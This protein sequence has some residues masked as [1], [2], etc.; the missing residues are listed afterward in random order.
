MDVEMEDA[1]PSRD[2]HL[3][4]ARAGGAIGASIRA[5]HAQSSLQIVTADHLIDQALTEAG[6]HIL[7]KKTAFADSGNGGALPAYPSS[8]RTPT[9]GRMRR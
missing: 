8:A 3:K 2:D 5:T 6:A 9:P 1:G 4:R 7:A